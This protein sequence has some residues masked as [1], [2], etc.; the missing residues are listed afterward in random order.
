MARPK[1]GEEKN[2]PVHL[3]FRVPE[4]TDTALRK[5]AEKRGAPMSDIV[6]EALD[7]YLKR[8]AKGGSR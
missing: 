8:Q 6:N 2:R 5:I 3:G 1:A 4:E 7:A